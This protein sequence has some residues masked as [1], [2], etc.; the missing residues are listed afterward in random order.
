[1][2]KNGKKDVNAKGLGWFALCVE[3]SCER[4]ALLGLRGR[5]KKE[6]KYF[7]SVIHGRKQNGLRGKS[8]G[9][10]FHSL[11]IKLSLED[12]GSSARTSS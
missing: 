6:R 4:E 10:T 2:L 1:M 8:I 9:F 12:S 5:R 11:F 7:R 3:S